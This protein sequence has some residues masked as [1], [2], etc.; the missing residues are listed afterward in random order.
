[1]VLF[2]LTRTYSI[3]SLIGIGIVAIVLSVF[4]RT[5]A[6]RSL[7][8]HETSSNVAIAKALSNVIWPRYANF[9]TRSSNIA[10]QALAL[11]PEIS[12]L[13]SEVLQKIHGLRVVKV[14]IYNLDG[15]TV[16]STE[17]AQI[18]NSGADN[19][20]FQQ[21]RNGEVNSN[22]VFSAHFSSTEQVIE[23]RNLLSSYIPVH[24][25]RDGEVEG[26][27]EVYT[28]VT[29]LVED[30]KK[31][32]RTVF[33]VITLLLLLLYLFLFMIVRRASRIIK[34]HESEERKAQAE[35]I[36]YM[37]YH[38]A[39]TTLPNR[40]M[41]KEK[42]QQ[43][44]SGAMQSVSPL[45]ILFLDIDRFKVIN[46]SLGHDGG[47]AV[48]VKTAKRIRECIQDSDTAFR[49]GGDEF[50]VILQNSLSI[51]DAAQKA[52]KLLRKISKPMLIGDRNIVVTA[53]I[54]IAVFPGATKD[55][56]RLLKDANSAMHEAKDSGRNRCVF[57]TQEMNALAQQN[58]EFELGL[59]NALAKQE[60]IIHYQPRV[61]AAL[62]TVTGVEALLRWQHSSRGL[63]MP[64]I[65]IPMLEETGL[66][67]PVG[68]WVLQH[69]C[70]HC[71]RWHD[72]G[73]STLR[74]SVN[75][76]MKQFRGGSLLTSVRRALKKSGLPARFL[77]LEL[78]E[79]VLVN[80]AENALSLMNELKK[81]GV[82]IAIDDFGT[83]Y[84][85]LN[86]LR[87]FPIDLLKIDRTFINE[88][89]T[90]P[91]DA[92]I[93]TTIAAMA[94][95]LH[96][97]MLAEGVETREQE[98]FLKSLGCHEMQGFLFSKPLTDEQVSTEIRK[99]DVLLKLAGVESGNNISAIGRSAT[100]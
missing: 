40:A 65:F 30:I 80:D 15:L 60:F 37:A 19:S 38:D 21:A 94:K 97:G 22:L 86:Y 50:I 26:V 28:D 29:M 18:G 4:Y 91:G 95:N 32:E 7:I 9:V 16:F 42:Y 77:E 62:G 24:G 8:E 33:G 99:L 89:T 78:T 67:I 3:A 75:L 23:N 98:Q 48:L 59:H 72:N 66:I 47:D 17:P 58:H 79:S 88:V 57:Y 10:P 84:S 31:T 1:M 61:N 81:I 55:A 71:K 100:G 44:C 54:G 90:N 6:V 76:S 2:R 70:M 46:E 87:H 5:L 93:T 56:Q 25:T 92:A 52:K 43:V 34:M 68:E 74:V 12:S 36:H 39:L 27:F 49:L 83:G 11:Q 45:G 51:E 82:W 69:A 13:R 96:I 63:I 53:S 73:H 20:G 64:E 14:K 41:F 85:S 35:Q